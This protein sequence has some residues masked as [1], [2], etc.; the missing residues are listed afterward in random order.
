ML[1]KQDLLRAKRASDSEQAIR[2]CTGRNRVKNWAMLCNRFA[3]FKAIYG[4]FIWRKK[5][6]ERKRL[7]NDSATK[8]I[9]N[10]RN[11]VARKAPIA[12]RSRILGNAIRQRVGAR[13][14]VLT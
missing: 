8:I 14:V 4:A 13:L 12:L 3:F 6:V 2:I 10:F 7:E 9:R 1:H 5:V 11:L